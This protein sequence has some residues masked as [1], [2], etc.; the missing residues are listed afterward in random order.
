VRV[1]KHIKAGRRVLTLR[2]FQQSSPDDALLELLLGDDTGEAPESGPSRLNDLIDEIHALGV[3]DGVR[4]HMAG[5]GKR[6]FKDD[7]LVITGRAQTSMRVV[8]G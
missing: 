6:A 3:W 4:M 7:D 2:G 1:P 8:K 5:H